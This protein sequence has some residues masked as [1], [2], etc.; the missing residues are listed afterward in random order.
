MRLP[1][2]LSIPHCG[3]HL[4]ADVR[5]AMALTDAQIAESVDIG[6]YEIF[7]TLC[8]QDIISAHFNR[9]LVDLN[10]APDDFSDHG[11]VA[12]RDYHGR[13]VYRAGDEPD[14]TEMHRRVLAYHTPFH[15]H[16]SRAVEDPQAV[17]LIDC[18]S[19]NGIGP[20]QAPDTG[21]PRK[22]IVL[23]NHGDRLGRDLSAKNRASCG[24][25]TL[26]AG[27]TAF[28]SQ[29]FSVSVNYPY[30]G[31]FI[32]AEYGRRLRSE[33]RFAVQ[34]EINQALYVP[35][36]TDSPDSVLISRVARKVQNALTHWAQ[37][38]LEK[39]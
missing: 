10:R 11:V 22:D 25:P 19:L 16:L 31:G 17:G 6:T 3:H 7:G 36:G 4:P 2:I 20:L 14:Q 28:K 34:I 32:V 26:Q 29:G 33:G 21:Q 37:T 38:I 27:I 39:T 15:H 13:A 1:F 18:H 24:L 30:R 5:K 23:S 9:L 8:A 12:K 35:K